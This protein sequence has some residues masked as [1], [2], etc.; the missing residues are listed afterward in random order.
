MST[1]G[2]KRQ[3]LDRTGSFSLPP[4]P[5]AQMLNYLQHVGV[6]LRIGACLLAAVM[7]W[8]LTSG[9]TGSFPFRRGYIPDRDIVASVQFAVRD[10]EATKRQRDQARRETL[11]VYSHDRQQLAELRKALED[12]VFQLI[13]APSFESLEKSVWDEFFVDDK[14]ADS[15]RKTP[16][17][18][19]PL[20]K[21]M[22]EEDVFK[23]F[24]E[25]FTGDMKLA[26][27]ELAIE[28]AFQRVEEDGLLENLGHQLEDGSQIAILVHPRGNPK[29]VHQVEV[30][31]VRIAEVA[32]LL[33]TRV[34]QEINSLPITKEQSSH[35]AVLVNQWLQHQRLPV[36]L[37]LNLERT[38]QEY[39]TAMDRIG[40]ARL[41]Y[42]PGDR[43]A[44][45]G[46]PLSSQDLELLR[47]EYQHQREQAGWGRM[48]SC[49]LAFFG[50][51]GALY[52]L[53][54]C[55][56]LFH[57]PRILNDFRHL[58]T[59]L[60][61]VVITGSLMHVAA[62]DDWRV[63]IVPI[64]LFAM[65]IT[66]AYHRE[67][68]LL[69]AAA[70]SLVHAVSQGSALTEWLILL[71]AVAASV[72][73]LARIRSRT[74]LIYVGLCTGVVVILTT[75]GVGT[76]VGQMFG[77]SDVSMFS[78]M[79]NAEVVWNPQFS[80]ISGLI[81]GAF[82]Y[83]GCALTAGFLMTGLLP[84]VEWL[85]DVQT[86]ISLLEL[87]DAAHPL[88]QELSRRAPG[89]YNHSMNVASL[90]EA[91]AAAIGA[92]SLLVRVGAYF[93]DIGKMLKPEY[94]V[95]NQVGDDNR[96]ESLLPAMSSL[97]IIAHVKDGADLAEH[98]NLPQPIIDFI[99]QHHGTTLVEFFYIEATKRNE[100]DPNGVETD[101]ANFRY[102]GPKPQSREAGI[103]MLADAVESASR[104][105][106]DPA[107]ARIEGLVRKISEKRLNAGQFH[108]CGL[109]LQEL[110]AIEN[111]LIKSLAAVHHGRVK[112]PDQEQTA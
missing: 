14:S 108:D 36:T 26:S 66:I 76:L 29:L 64:T 25:S 109:T 31:D 5:W 70:V 12:K 39:E 55:Y 46:K 49:S 87:G 69:L 28:R 40:E 33:T 44:V 102:P 53:C 48:V 78:T 104:S 7:M 100:D 52:V 99:E 16:A 110:H 101:E 47:F 93:H 3:L 41:V 18:I 88:L 92:N 38:E 85:F 83:G 23:A 73:M 86:D 30:R 107:P 90:G 77:A 94:F 10:P 19:S 9:W 6:L 15:E 96:H 4:S 75:I 13:G 81:Q 84:V 68:G 54:G 105:L 61:L 27:F 71:S 8:W 22:T 74:K 67:L 32:G 42:R 51:Y 98:H 63:E 91:A 65:T 60:S 62:R 20:F 79:E 34:T 97:V 72:L 17:D 2:P 106:E 45:G 35:V 21:G 111:S 50:M 95:E 37:E 1:G 103:M 57:E 80:F 89:T 11:C 24:Q 59:I 56:I 82:W 58:T 43:L 112:Y